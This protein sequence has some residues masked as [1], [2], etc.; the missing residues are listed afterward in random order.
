MPGKRD[1]FRGRIFS[2]HAQDSR[3]S[4]LLSADETLGCSKEAEPLGP[5]NDIAHVWKAA[6]VCCGADSE[7]SSRAGKNVQSGSMI[8]SW[9]F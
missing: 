3:D 9:F 8:G 5:L 7:A 6:E 1:G 2:H 4:C